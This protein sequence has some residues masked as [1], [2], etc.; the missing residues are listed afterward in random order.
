[1]IAGFLEPIEARRYFPPVKRGSALKQ[2]GRVSAAQLNIIRG[3]FERER[4]A[5]LPD[6]TKRQA[7]IWTAIVNDEPREHFATTATRQ[8]LA[9]YCAH[10]STIE[11]LN[12][13]VNAFASQWLKDA[14]GK[15]ALRELLKMREVETRVAT[16]LATT[17]RLTNQSR[18]TP[19][20][21]QTASRNAAKGPKPWEM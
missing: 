7:E 10:R 1:V 13:A 8:L 16:M 21:A 2:R 4:P 15:H 19:M 14:D 3:D 17:L 18:Y 6:L 20:A 12:T 5:P 9:S 11:T